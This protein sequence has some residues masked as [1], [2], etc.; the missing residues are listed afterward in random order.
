MARRKVSNTN[1]TISISWDDKE[2]F[3]KYAQYTKDTKTGKRSESDAVLF[4]RILN[5]YA[6]RFPL[7]PDVKAKTTYPTKTQDGDQQDS[8]F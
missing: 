1:T 5:D 3:R 7:A 8:S 6:E 4:N 2:T